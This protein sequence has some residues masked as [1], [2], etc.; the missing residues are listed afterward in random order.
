MKNRKYFSGRKPLLIALAS[1][2]LLATACEKLNEF[3][4]D[5]PVTG[6]VLNKSETTI[7]VGGTEQLAAT[8][9]P[10]NASDTAVFWSS[11]NSAAASVSNRG[12][13]R[14]LAEGTADIIA[15]TQDGG[16]QALCKVTVSSTAVAVTGVSL[17][18]E[19]T[20]ILFGGTEQ[21]VATITPANATNQNLTWSSNAPAVASV[22][23]GGMVTGAG[24]GTAIITVTT[25]DG[26]FT[27]TC[28]V[29]VSLIDN[30]AAP[31]ITPNGGTLWDGQNVTFQS[32]T[33]GATF[34]Y[35][36]D[37]SDPKTSPTAATGSSVYISMPMMPV[38]IRVVASKAGYADSDITVSSPF[39]LAS[40]II[41]VSPS[42][43][44][45]NPGTLQAPK[46]DLQDAI[47]TADSLYATAHVKAAEGTYSIS[48]V[49]NMRSGISLVGSYRADFH[50]RNLAAYPSIIHDTQST[51]TTVSFSAVTSDTGLDGFVIQGVDCTG[52]GG[53]GVSIG[54]CSPIIRNNTLKNRNSG[55]NQMSYSIAMSNGSSPLIYNNLMIGGDIYQSVIFSIGSSNGSACNPK[56]YNNTISMGNGPYRHWIFIIRWDSVSVFHHPFLK[57]NLFI[58]FNAVESGQYNYSTYHMDSGSSHYPSCYTTNLFYMAPYADQVGAYVY[59]GSTNPDNINVA[60]YTTKAAYT[61]SSGTQVLTYNDPAWR[62]IVNQNPLFV[63]PAG[64]DYRLSA[65]SPARNTGTDLS[66][67]IPA[68][69]R[70]GNPR[71]APWSIGAYE[72][73]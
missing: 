36:V 5:V 3:L 42:G 70:D 29:A 8:V 38:T 13:V 62:N 60:N 40:E 9:L 6:I 45:V 46:L 43:A 65:S 59:Y 35:T 53:I 27:D 26:S 69:D 20:T 21:L 54:S 18:K 34:T 73:D 52:G 51:G 39:I 50:E 15:E 10:Q 11:S 31:S 63:N 19:N 12:L 1:F 56:I 37:G 55:E 7:L 61:Q 68:F 23:E 57:N 49:I 64:G 41:F 25:V 33:E 44:M 16:Y 2:C 67:E 48:T 30:A 17:N 24:V 14:G 58:N 72:R 66:G 22:S 47:D 71:T 4:E 28:G 32:A